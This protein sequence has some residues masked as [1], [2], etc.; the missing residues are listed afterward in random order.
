MR[1]LFSQDDDT[2]HTRPVEAL[3][4]LRAPSAGRAGPLVRRSKVDRPSGTLRAGH[5]TARA[6]LP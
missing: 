3:A 4:A 6:A 1:G 5:E 2:R